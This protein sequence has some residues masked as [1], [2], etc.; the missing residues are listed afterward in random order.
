MGKCTSTSVRR[1]NT[2]SISPKFSSD[3]WKFY[4]FLFLMW[5][6]QILKLSLSFLFCFFKKKFV[7]V[8]VKNQIPDAFLLTF[9]KKPRKKTIIRL[10]STLKLKKQGCVWWDG[11]IGGGGGVKAA[12]WGS[13]IL[14]KRLRV[15][16]R[17]EF[18]VYRIQTCFLFVRPNKKHSSI[19]LFEQI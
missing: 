15:L 7:V 14:I 18:T 8:F 16:E 17:G 12:N 6:T 11:G 10:K 9:T 13:R 2:P 1:F 3:F 4:F 5:R 19:Y